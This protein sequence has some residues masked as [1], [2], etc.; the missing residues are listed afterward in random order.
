MKEYFH[1]L[2]SFND[3]ANKSIIGCLIENNVR[4]EQIIKL[5]SHLLHAQHNWYKRLVNQQNDTPVW[6]VLPLEQ[7]LA[8]SDKNTQQWLNYLQLH[9]EN[10][11]KRVIS[12][13]NLKGLHCSNEIQDILTHVVNHSTYH[14]GQV[15]LFIREHGFAPPS[16]DQI[17]YATL[18]SKTFE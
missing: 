18:F 15:A 14:R 17:M 10:D 13:F 9:D 4:H 2:F 5:T 7:M 1:R 12:Y 6:E 16:T 8:Y 11:F 3:W